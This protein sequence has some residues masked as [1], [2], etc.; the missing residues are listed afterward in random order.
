MQS[1]TSVIALHE[2]DRLREDCRLVRERDAGVDVEHL[3]ARLDLRERVGDDGL[4]VARRHL[5]GELLAARRIDPLAD[6]HERPVEADHDLLRRAREPR[7]GH[8][9]SLPSA[10]TRRSST[11]SGYA[12]LEPGRLLRDLLVELVAALA[13]LPAPLGEVR[14]RA[15]QAGA[16]RGARRSPPGSARELGARRRPALLRGDLGGDVAPPDDGQLRQRG[17]SPRS[18]AATGRG[19]RIRS[20][21]PRTRGR[22]A[23]LPPVRARAGRRRPSAR[24]R[25]GAC[26]CR[27]TAAGARDGGR[28]RG[29]GY[30]IASKCRARKSV[31]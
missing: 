31:R 7:L 12:A 27:S 9:E 4:V 20:V 2:L 25:A 19:R 26:S 13:R 14:V 18:A 5:L 15:D 21:A 23:R 6:D 8:Y 29:R 22:C 3:R 16:H 17:L 28:A 30:T 24:G 10:R 1:G 11:S